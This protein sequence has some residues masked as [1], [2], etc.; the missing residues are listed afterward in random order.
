MLMFLKNWY[1]APYSKQNRL[2][3]TALIYIFTIKFTHGNNRI[4]KAFQKIMTIHLEIIL[5]VIFGT[6]WENQQD[7]MLF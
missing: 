7:L 1:N 2:G 5:I 4:H 6:L 3:I